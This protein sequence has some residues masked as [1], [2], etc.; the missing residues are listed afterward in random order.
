MSYFVY[1]VE[2]ADKSFYTGIT[3]DVMRRVRE[4]NGEKN[5]GAKSTRMRRPVHI[6]YTE[7]FPSRSLASKREYA[8]K[9]LTRSEKEVLIQN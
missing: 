5:K 7:E 2:C 6:V 4:H 3:T 1:I 8:I 9:K